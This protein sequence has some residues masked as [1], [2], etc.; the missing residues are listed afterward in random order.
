MRAGNAYPPLSF[1]VVATSDSCRCIDGSDGYAGN[2]SVGGV[3]NNAVQESHSRNPAHAANRKRSASR[4]V[5][6]DEELC[7]VNGGRTT[8]ALCTQKKI[9][10]KGL[11][12][13]VL[14]KVVLGIRKAP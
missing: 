9:R 13:I 12:G 1:V 14:I 5:V 6:S 2:Q 4:V 10:R 3:D 8:P 11:L 7:R